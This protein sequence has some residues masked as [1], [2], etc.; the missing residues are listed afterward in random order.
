MRT[1]GHS[2]E[3]EPEEDLGSSLGRRGPEASPGRGPG[4]EQRG[5]TRGRPVPGPT[6]PGRSWRRRA[7]V[8]GAPPRGWGEEG[9]CRIP[10]PLGNWGSQLRQQI[11]GRGRES[12]GLRGPWAHRRPSGI[13]SPP[14]V[15]PDGSAG[16]GG[17]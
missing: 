13:R 15:A 9:G 17:S 12:G 2:Q 11:P 7:R 16:P 6:W 4:L 10:G 8:L 5:R 14:V 3:A 1:S